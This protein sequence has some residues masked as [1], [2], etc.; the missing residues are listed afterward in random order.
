MNALPNSKSVRNDH[1]ENWGLF[2][3]A[4]DIERERRK[5]RDLRASQWWK[6]QLAKRKCHYCGCESLPADLTMDHIVPLSRGG[7]SSKGNVVP[8]CKN[9]NN[10]KRQLLPMEWKLYVDRL[11]HKA[12][13]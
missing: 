9:C 4:E 2:V 12:I 8:C 1:L 5:A 11:V 7:K 13:Y 3:E 10:Q 6:R